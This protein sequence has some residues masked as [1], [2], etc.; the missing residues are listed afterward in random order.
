FGHDA[1]RAAGCKVASLQWPQA[2]AVSLEHGRGHYSPVTA[3][4]TG[5]ALRHAPESS[6][7]TAKKVIMR[8]IR[9]GSLLGIPI[10]V[11]PSWFVLFGLATW[12]LATQVYPNVL[13]DES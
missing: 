11:N 13:P 2:N 5:K 6:L 1:E 7:Y 10:L 3:A 8:S 9:L 4:Q 12:M